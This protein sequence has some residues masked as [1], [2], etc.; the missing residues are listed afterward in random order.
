MP[1]INPRSLAGPPAS[2]L[3]PSLHAPGLDPGSMPAAPKRSY[4][5]GTAIAAKKWMDVWVAGQGAGAVH[6]VRPVAEVVDETE[7]EFL[8][9]R[10]RFAAWRPSATAARAAAQGVA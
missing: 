4:N 7:R 10:Q 3:K 9:A 6:A 8:A 2:W 1:T 5:N